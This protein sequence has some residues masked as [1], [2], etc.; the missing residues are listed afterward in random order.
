MLRIFLSSEILNV[1]FFAAVFLPL[2]LVITNEPVFPQAFPD[3]SN[4]IFP[5][6]KENLLIVTTDKHINTF[7]VSGNLFYAKSFANFNA[8]LD[9]KASSAY[10]SSSNESF[11]ASQKIKFALDYAP[12]EHL[13][14]GALVNRNYFNDDKR[15]SIS[16]A[17]VNQVL[18][19][20][21]INYGN[22]ELNLFGGISNNLQMNIRDNG[23]TYGAEGYFDNLKMEDQF[24]SGKFHFSNEDISPRK[25]YERAADI[26]LQSVISS[27]FT[28]Q[29]NLGYRETRRD[30][31]L[32]IDSLL[33]EEFVTEKNIEKRVE[34]NFFAE[35]KMFYNFTKNFRFV[36]SGKIF[37]QNINRAKKYVN[38]DYV[39]IS[40]F[41]P[42]MERFAL[43]F[44][45]GINYASPEI[46]AFAKINYYEKEE[47][48]SVGQIEGANEI[49]YQLR[50]KQEERKNNIS[51][52]AFLTAGASY[53]IT[54]KNKLS[55]TLFH[56][57]LVYDTPSEENF[58][59]RDELLTMLRLRYS[60][61]FSY[62]FRM[63][64]DL[65]GSMN[66]VVYIFSERS[67]NNNIKRILKLA[68]AGIYEGKNVLSRNE[69]EISANYTVYDFEDII[70]NSQSFAFR[71]VVF[72]DSTSA[73]L[74]KNF[75]IKFYGYAKLSEQ[76]EF[77]WEEFA[78]KP[79]QFRNEIFAEPSF[80]LN[81][82]FLKLGAGLRY[83]SLKTYGYEK[84][85]LRLT[86]EYLSLG[87][88][89]FAQGR[90]SNKLRL[91][92]RGWYEFISG[93]NNFQNRNLNFNFHLNWKI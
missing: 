44:S 83:F 47:T 31:Y 88:S 61:K 62:L 26:S 9:A 50:M 70:Q 8:M 60:K 87:P 23:L 89:F 57:K 85:N 7:N 41:D 80:F 30:F 59:D 52:L 1:S 37:G 76:G 22:A 2:L 13:K 12:F 6:D 34:E 29:I 45:S 18:L 64:F 63:N 78:E 48:F 53:E 72:K 56:R 65:E 39:T 84:L 82:Y 71:Q 79:F 33:G 55:L 5:H 20:A 69:A 73:A 32:E 67:S 75:G 28:N 25:N 16:N 27:S 51:K 21:G 3:T 11:R 49:L 10:F 43:D 19:Y 74:S 91:D 90:I 38:P 66:H 81:V 54:P 77:S 15:L 40:S 35:E 58:D 17:E 93:D 24:V 92:L 68:V 14:T 46:S 42:R 36:F 86:S 4:Y